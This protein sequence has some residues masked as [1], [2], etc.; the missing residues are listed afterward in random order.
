MIHDWSDDAREG[1]AEEEVVG[2]GSD[3]RGSA[4]G[5]QSSSNSKEAQECASAL[6]SWA[7]KARLN[8]ADRQFLKEKLFPSDPCTAWRLVGEVPPAVGEP[9]IAV[10]RKM[11]QAMEAQDEALWQEASEGLREVMRQAAAQPAG[12]EEVNATGV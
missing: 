10:A 11:R 3:A 1:A 2:A 7:R 4:V 5:V 12:D 6:D 8:D 9:M